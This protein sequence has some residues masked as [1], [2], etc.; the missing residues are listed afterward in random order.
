MARVVPFH[1][2]VARA[3]PRSAQV[4]RPIARATAAGALLYL[5]S[6]VGSLVVRGTQRLQ[7]RLDAWAEAR[8]QRA[9]DRA[10]WEL[11]R[12]DARL[13]AELVALQQ[14]AESKA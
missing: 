4:R 11:A 14:H 8:R 9:E 12:S 5:L 10:T 3:A 1:P 6:L 7:L 2:T 13:M